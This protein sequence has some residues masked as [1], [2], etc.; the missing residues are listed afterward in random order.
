MWRTVK[1][2]DKYEVNTKGV[3]RN[4]K[5]KRPLKP[6]VCKK[7]GYLRVRL[8]THQGKS[9]HILVHRVVANTF[10]DNPKNLPEVNHKDKNTSNNCVDNLE[11]CTSQYNSRHSKGKPVIMYCSLDKSERKF[12]CI[13]E[14]SEEMNI[15]NTSI[16]RC[17]KGIQKH[18]GGFIWK[19][20]EKK[21][22]EL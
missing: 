9:K 11:W 16:T 20:A 5:T 22:V 7:W 1:N 3:I 19:Y 2:Y 21:E 18:A 8:Y 14:A 4:K 6:D 10:L 15:D 13:R 12:S 17:C